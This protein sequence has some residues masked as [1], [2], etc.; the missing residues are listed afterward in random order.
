MKN[1]YE[2]KEKYRKDQ[3]KFKEQLKTFKDKLLQIQKSCMVTLEKI[4]PT[5]DNFDIME[6][7]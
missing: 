3:D 2:L 4:S 6:T 1:Y 7:P 5:Q